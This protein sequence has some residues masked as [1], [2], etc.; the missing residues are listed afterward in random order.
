MAKRTKAERKERRQKIKERI[1]KGIKAVGNAAIFAPL[2]PFKPAI[3]T[4]VKRT[5]VEPEKRLPKLVDQFKERVLKKERYDNEFFDYT[6][7]YDQIHSENLIDDAGSIVKIIIDWVKG[8]KKKKDDGKKLTE[9]E[10]KIA[11]H[12]EDV[13]EVMKEGVKDD[14]EEKIGEKVTSP[15]GLLVIAAVIYFGFIKK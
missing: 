14:V 15:V 11:T 1:K 2:L 12:A 9:L 3:H 13:E 6:G 10:D 7:Y 8:I 5:G 4:A